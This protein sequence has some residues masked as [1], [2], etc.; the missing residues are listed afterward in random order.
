MPDR[1]RGLP[2]GGGELDQHPPPVSQARTAGDVAASFQ[3]VQDAGER[4][5]AGARRPAQ[6]RHTPAAAV[7][8][9]GQDI[10]L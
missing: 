4:G 5:G 3:P 7:G 1:G 6:F 8:E 2:A 10:D 9:V